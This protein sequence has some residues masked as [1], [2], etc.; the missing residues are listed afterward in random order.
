MDSIR[1]FRS[2]IQSWR[3]TTILIIVIGVREVGDNKG[4]KQ[5]L[6]IDGKNEFDQDVPTLGNNFIT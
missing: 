5:L 1:E 4:E 6:I 2:F 3:S